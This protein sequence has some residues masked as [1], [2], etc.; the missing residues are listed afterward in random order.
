MTEDMKKWIEECASEKIRRTLWYN[1]S[2]D[3]L[4]L[5]QQDTLALC[6]DWLYEP[7]TDLVPFTEKRVEWTKDYWNR[8]YRDLGEN[9]SRKRFDY[10]MKIAE[11]AVPDVIAEKKVI[12]EEKEHNRIEAE[13]KAKKQA[14][15]MRA[16]KAR[17]A[18]TVSSNPL[19]LQ[20]NHSQPANPPQPAR[21]YRESEPARQHRKAKEKQR[22]IG[23]VAVVIIVVVLI[24]LLKK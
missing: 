5:A 9:F 20:T 10:L 15:A 8:I 1:M 18:Q 7:H 23:L 14:E 16:E 3:P 11:T 4:L 17:M 13:R 22:L 24:I 6:G 19:P 12:L 21:I 2:S